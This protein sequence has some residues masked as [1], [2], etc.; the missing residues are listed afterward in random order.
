MQFISSMRQ[1]PVRAVRIVGAVGM[2]IVLAVSAF[3]PSAFAASH[4][5][6]ATVQCVIAAGDA[7]INSR[8]SA[9]NTLNTKVTT[10]LNDQ[11]ITSQQA[12]ALQG[13]ITTNLNGLAA[14][15]SKLDA[16]T[17]IS[18]AREDVKNIFVQFRIYAVI[19][20]REYNALWLDI[21]VNVQA[22]LHDAE[23]KIEAAIDAVS[24]LPD[25]DGDKEKINTAFADF[26]NEVAATDGQIDGAQGLLP[27]LTV[28]AFNNT[29]GTYK[30]DFTD[31]RNDIRTS[32]Q[33]IT[34]AAKDLHQIAQLLKDLVGAQGGG[35]AAA[36][37]T[38]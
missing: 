26:K 34:A 32:H 38:A 14:L 28:S 33:D 12:S 9:L 13:D 37:P 18:A 3:T 11:H 5:S 10:Q 17:Q 29:P 31:F 30:A 23:P 20:P 1:A 16:E 21:L 8:D 19:L 35:T 2:G 4:A 15:K 24:G 25:K 6:C 7:L 22:R 36:T 27:T